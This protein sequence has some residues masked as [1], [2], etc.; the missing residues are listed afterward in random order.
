MRYRLLAAIF[1]LSVA[2]SAQ[3]LS[4][5]QLRKFL[6][7]SVQLK[8]TDKEVAGF[9]ARAKLTEKLDDRTIEDFQSLGI[10]PKTLAELRK[11]R[12]ESAGLSAAAP[13]APEAKP[14]PIP[15]PSAEE[16]A[17]IIAEVR[18]YAANYTKTLP[19]FICTQ[20]TR[21]YAAP[22]PG[23]KYGGHSGDDPSWQLQDTL[24]L[25]LSYFEQKEDYKLILVNNTITQQDYRK[26]GGATSTGEFG[27]MLKD[28]FDRETE[29]RLEWDHWATLRGRRAMAFAY[30]VE[31][32]NAHWELVYENSLR[33]YPAY[34]GLV[35]IDKDTHQVLRL[36]LVSENVPADFPI[37]QA[38]T[39]LD[40]D[41]ETI[42]D[43]PFLLPLKAETRMRTSDVLTRNDE[44]FR[45]YRK[46]STDSEIKY[47]TPDPL[48]ED[49]TKEQSP[50]K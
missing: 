7:S 8:Q 2:A 39:I 13:L 27:S 1:V 4:V 25:R 21:R 33:I 28:V 32:K 17:A 23:G 12:D 35:Y 44:E 9:L 24:T 47:D 31:Q 22:V 48:P 20:V 16:Q 46:F 14:R 3:S 50:P 49:Q 36:T 30:R 18:D 29:A 5:Q 11:L 41:Y 26:L 40:Y 6:Q 19:D 34:S 15:P 45:L 38:E 42:S 43:H 10:G 37:H